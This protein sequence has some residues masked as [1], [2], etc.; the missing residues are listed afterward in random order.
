MKIAILA[1]PLDNQNAGV[2]V[3]TR[4]MI[5]SLIKHNPGHQ[6]ILIRQKID[7]EL[8][9]VQQIIVPARN[10]PPGAASMR[11]FFTIPRI[12][13]REKVDVVIE[14]AHF[15][16][17]NLP[18]N[19]ARVTVIHD[20][21]PILFPQLHRWH[22]QILQR[23]FLKG[24]LKRADLI[25]AN[26]RNTE[27]DIL[28]TY[29]FSKGKTKMIYPGMTD[30]SAPSK[31]DLNAQFGIKKPYF[32]T[33][34][35]I[36]PRKNH[37][38]L[39]SAFTLFRQRHPIPYQLVIT[40]G[41]GWKSEAFFSALDQNAYKKDI[42]LTGFIAKEQL[43]QLN[44]EACAMIYP[45]KYEGFGFPVLEA[46]VWGSIPITASNSSLIEVGGP[47]AYYLNHEN[48]EELCLLMEEVSQ[49]TPRERADKLE[50]LKKHAENFS[51]DTFGK[52][53]W[54]EL[55]NMMI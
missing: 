3:Y 32:L 24:I 54:Q 31:V 23:F 4:E 33:V 10:F 27:K 22:S 1:D 45:S 35:T 19:I 53:M 34:G 42:I 26:S 15:G 20:L 17:F 30:V 2:H 7:P 11:L 50:L 40:G 6:I 38:L 13:K 52:G 39:L 55:E 14:P 37:L 46:M 18:K 36:E 8:S 21:T 44:A 41:K 29:S 25:I 12:L 48:S 5:T 43:P 16:P 49:L 9:S 47:Q 28:E 51:W